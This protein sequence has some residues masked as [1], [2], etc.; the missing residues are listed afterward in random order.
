MYNITT[1]PDEALI[2]LASGQ[3]RQAIELLTSLLKT[4]PANPE[5]W[6][7]MAVA[8]PRQ[9]SIQALRYVLLLD[10]PN[11]VARR[12]LERWNEYPQ[13]EFA[14]ELRDIWK[15]DE[16]T[17]EV[18]EEAPALAAFGEEMPT[19][20]LASSQGE[21]RFGEETPTL[22]EA[23]RRLIAISS[24]LQTA[25]HLPPLPVTPAMLPAEITAQLKV[26]EAALTKSKIPTRLP[27]ESASSLEVPINRPSLEYTSHVHLN[28]NFAPGAADSGN[29]L[30]SRPIVRNSRQFPIKPAY[31][32]F[33]V[34][35]ILLL[36]LGFAAFQVITTIPT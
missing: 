18:S 23:F 34:L 36:M 21:A 31:L 1:L 8:L 13:S 20:F 17:P 3:K 16:I 30:S 14:L 15:A 7:A 10:P 5:L 22:P 32:I 25:K 26:I 33:I 19:Q 12:N 2:A 9:Q 24:A 29:S 11:P 28:Q 35:A 4:E 27:L 6:L